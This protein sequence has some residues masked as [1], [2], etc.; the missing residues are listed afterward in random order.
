MPRR[1]FDQFLASKVEK[2]LSRNEERADLPLDERCEG[3]VEVAFAGDLCEDNLMSATKQTCCT[4]MRR[5]GRCRLR[6]L[7]HE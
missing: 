5:D 3:R 4:A 2:W 6:V 7:C 1:Q